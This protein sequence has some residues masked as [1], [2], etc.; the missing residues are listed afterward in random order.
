[1]NLSLTNKLHDVTTIDAMLK[2]LSNSAEKGIELKIIAIDGEVHIAKDILLLFSPV[3]RKM[4]S[5]S[6]QALVEP[7]EFVIIMKDVRTSCLRNLRSLLTN[8]KIQKLLNSSEIEEICDAGTMLGINIEN[9]SNVSGGNSQDKLRIPSTFFSNANIKKEPQKEPQQEFPHPVPL[10]EVDNK[11][12]SVSDIIEQSQSPF[13]LGEYICSPPSS[14]LR[15]TLRKVH[16]SNSV[17]DATIPDTENLSILAVESV[18]TPRS[19]I[20]EPHLHPMATID[21]QMSVDSDDSEIETENNNDVETDKPNFECELCVYKTTDSKLMK[22]HKKDIHKRRSD[23]DK[24]SEKSKKKEAKYFCNS[25]D[26]KTHSSSMAKHHPSLKPGHI[27]SKICLRCGRRHT[28]RHPCSFSPDVKCLECF[29]SGHVQFLHRP[30]SLKDY[31]EIKKLTTGWGIEIRY[32]SAI[33]RTARNVKCHTCSFETIILNDMYR[34]MRD[35]HNELYVF[36]CETCPYKTH[37]RTDF[38][39]HKCGEV[40]YNQRAPAP[41]VS[42]LQTQPIDQAAPTAAGAPNEQTSLCFICGMHHGP[43]CHSSLDAQCAFRGCGQKGHVETL[44]YPKNYN[45]YKIIKSFMP[46]LLLSAITQSQ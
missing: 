36:H 17:K 14:P 45:D 23:K 44:H 1:M 6:L 9:L 18:S 31:E 37:K 11:D 27:C 26:Y 29:K 19:D 12:S 41:N 3:V 20:Q 43:R 35:V 4:F 15:V 24:V 7:K 38:R 10:L 13:E 8:G 16:N 32:P 42:G 5:E 46:D 25:C 33:A 21:D 40:T 34:H 30:T 2:S 39:L 22:Q 28:E